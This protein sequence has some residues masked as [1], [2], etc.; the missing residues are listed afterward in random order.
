MAAVSDAGWVAVDDIEENGV[1]KDSLTGQPLNYTIPWMANEPNGGTEENC[2]GLYD[3]QWFDVSCSYSYHCLCENKPHPNL[4]LLGLCK[5]TLI[6]RDYQPQN[7]VKD[8]ESLT[9][10]GH[11]FFIFL[12][13]CKLV[14]NR[15]SAKYKNYVATFLSVK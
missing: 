6:D 12:T 3:C 7:D 10:V 11:P 4:K 1:W 9:I 14:Q 15:T 13:D 8:I 5:E 2:V